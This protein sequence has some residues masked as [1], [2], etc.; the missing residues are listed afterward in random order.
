MKVRLACLYQNESDRV[1]WHNR[2]QFSIANINISRYIHVSRHTL[3]NR[4]GEFES[5]KYSGA[6]GMEKLSDIFEHSGA[7]K[8]R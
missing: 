3:R 5:E 4:S 1:K 6:V 2:G 7:K 8:G